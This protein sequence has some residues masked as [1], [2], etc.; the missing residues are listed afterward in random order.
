MAFAAALATIDAM[1]AR[2]QVFHAHPEA[3]ITPDDAPNVGAWG[4][5]ADNLVRTGAWARFNLTPR[6]DLG[7]EGM[8]ARRTGTAGAWRAGAG[9]DVRAAVVPASRPLPFDLSVQAGLG[10]SDGGG[11]SRL[12]IPLGVTASR[13]L[14]TGS[15]REAVPFAGALLFVRSASFDAPTGSVRDT[16]L[17]LEL[18]GGVRL[19]LFD[20]GDAFAALHVGDRVMFVV[21]FA[22]GMPRSAPAARR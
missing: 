8:L 9:V 6:L 3:A 2:A 14:D 15:G 10:W 5:V 17:D 18:R 22:A 21:G 16:E 19:E 12:E 4:G 11:V 7:L 20:S 1:P 13:P